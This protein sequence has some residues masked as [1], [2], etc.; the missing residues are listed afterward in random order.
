[1]AAATAD[2]GLEEG[3]TERCKSVF[4]CDL[5]KLTEIELRQVFGFY[6]EI[7]LLRVVAEVVEEAVRIE[8]TTP[9]AADEAQQM[10]NHAAMKGKTSR[11]LL[12]ST[13][14]KILQTMEADHRLV[15]RG[16][17]LQIDSRGLRDACGLFG[18]VLDS[19]VELDEY[20]RSKGYGFA[21]FANR[22]DAQRALSSVNGM[23][24]GDSTVAVAYFEPKDAVLFTGCLYGRE[25][26][27]GPPGGG[28]L[29]GRADLDDLMKAPDVFGQA[30][31]ADQYPGQE[32]DWMGTD[33]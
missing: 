20:E 32:E 28:M 22:E 13:V 14:E 9:E 27:Q 5:P 7:A 6:G 31:Y 8:Y 4:V 3:A 1:M 2:R 11:C 26:P 15:I 30:G 17:D 12:T 10:V 33:W 21:H 23:Q 18:T 24:I 19:K 29:G 16:L 25:P